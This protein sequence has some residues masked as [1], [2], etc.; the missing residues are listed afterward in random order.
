M[1]NH[2]VELGVEICSKQLR[3]FPH[4]RH[5]DVDLPFQNLSGFCVIERDDVCERVVIEI[6]LV[7]PK[8][9]FIRAE[10]IREAVD[11]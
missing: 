7:D 10:D 11:G 3:I 6:F 5:A 2:T 8:K 1:D 9:I 4:T